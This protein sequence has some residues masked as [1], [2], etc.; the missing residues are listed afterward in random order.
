MNQYHPNKEEENHF[1]PVPNEE[2]RGSMNNEKTPEF[3]VI[4]TALNEI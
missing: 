1:V 3:D 4:G 2:L